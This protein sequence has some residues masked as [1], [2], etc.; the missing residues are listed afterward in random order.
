MNM[1]YCPAIRMDEDDRASHI[2]PTLCN[3]CG[4]C[5]QICPYDVIHRT[6]GCVEGNKILCTA[7]SHKKEVA[8]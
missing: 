6:G 4:T 1:F 8:Q 2:D 5:A 7:P 3:G